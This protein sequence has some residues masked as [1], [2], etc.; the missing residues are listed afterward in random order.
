MNDAYFTAT[1]DFTTTNGCVLKVYFVG[2]GELLILCLHGCGLS[3][4]SFGP[5]A[6]IL[7]GTAQVIAF[8][9]PCHGHSSKSSLALDNL[10]RCTVEV[11]R[12][13]GKDKQILLIGH[14]FGAALAI[15]VASHIDHVV[16]VVLIEFYQLN[17]FDKLI[18][19]MPTNFDYESFLEY[20]RDER[21][22]TTDF[23][24]YCLETQIVQADDKWQWI[25]N[26]NDTRTYWSEWYKGA[27]KDFLKLDAYKLLCLSSHT[28]DTELIVAH[29]QG[30][31]QLEII[32][33]SSHFLHESKP[34]A[35]GQIV[36]NLLRRMQSIKVFAKYNSPCNKL[37]L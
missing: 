2:K 13:Y 15:K 14:S 21:G 36:K 34:S 9:L 8:D 20:V 6:E 31:L 37:T 28:E 12:K 17:N 32:P 22:I 33:N 19:N 27:N 30:K 16:A 24:K 5:L 10:I 23:A 4:R 18:P 29:M 7:S 3:A 1:S 35:V 26:P 25:C 11:A